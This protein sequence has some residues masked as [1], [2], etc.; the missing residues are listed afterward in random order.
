MQSRCGG[1]G[2]ARAPGPE[3][4]SNNCARA[5]GGRTGSGKNR[6][7]TGKGR[8]DSRKGHVGSAKGSAEEDQRKGSRGRRV[9][10][11]LA[12]ERPETSTTVGRAGP[13]DPRL[14]RSG[15]PLAPGSFPPRPRPG[16]RKDPGGAVAPAGEPLLRGGPGGR[17]SK[18]G[19]REEGREARI[20]TTHP[21]IAHRRDPQGTEWRRRNSRNRPNGSE[22]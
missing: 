6:T 15:T 17:K 7:G 8:T 3:R 22:L 9:C 20:D 19:A 11:G 10:S 2:C 14:G 5:R 16:E 13:A 1:K 21:S 18:A 4:S 12:A